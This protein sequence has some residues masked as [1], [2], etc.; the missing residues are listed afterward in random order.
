MKHLQIFILL[1]LI[2]N[3]FSIA[4]TE[5]K[6]VDLTKTFARNYLGFEIGLTSSTTTLISTND[7]AYDYPN[8]FWDNS[9]SLIIGQRL[10]KR[11]LFIEGVIESS[12]I[13]YSL[14]INHPAFNGGNNDEP[15]SIDV[16]S[17]RIF[18]L[19]G[20]L[21]LYYPLLK[22]KLFISPLF[23][24]KISEIG[25]MNTSEYDN[26]ALY[27]YHTISKYKYV[28]GAVSGVGLNCKISKRF[29]LSLN[30]SNYLLLSSNEYLNQRTE[31]IT[32]VGQGE[33]TR[34]YHAKVN[35]LTHSIQL[36]LK[37]SLENSLFFKK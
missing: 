17:K 16:F 25:K 34:Y 22:D 32:G 12:K 21:I 4:Q 23:G 19:R 20:N 35:P 10:N 18:N 11:N 24:F 33:W 7:R 14:P 37:I 9:S 28:F 3:K 1:F 6:K 13:I 5:N 27:Y 2:F 8:T 15:T 26:W 36:G 30:Y 29:L 31:I